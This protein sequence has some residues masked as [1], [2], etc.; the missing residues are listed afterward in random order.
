MK[1]RGNEKEPVQTRKK[2]CK[3]YKQKT[4]SITGKNWGRTK[5]LGE[6]AWKDNQNYYTNLGCLYKK[7]KRHKINK[8]GE[9]KPSKGEIK[10]RAV[11]N[12]YS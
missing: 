4:K 8:I 11:T 12:L 10:E 9:G 2:C 1:C 7:K 5:R 6:K 3:K